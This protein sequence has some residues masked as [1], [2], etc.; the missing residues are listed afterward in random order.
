MS[1]AF[2]ALAGV[3]LGA[4]LGWGL[5]LGTEVWRE[6]LQNTKR[7]RHF[8]LEILDL[9][10]QVRISEDKFNAGSVAASDAIVNKLPTIDSFKEISL[11]LSDE[12]VIFA[13]QAVLYWNMI[14]RTE[15]TKIP[16][17]TALEGLA[18]MI[19]YWRPLRRVFWQ[20]IHW[21]EAGKCR[22]CIEA[23]L[24]EN[25]SVIEMRNGKK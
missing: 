19:S 21:K 11:F 4:V 5:F 3:T 2:F 1:E 24:N 17:L 16:E 23:L 7:L 18:E 15:P 22:A 9:I 6:R 13:G 25:P 14:R 8:E 12:E 10:T 20:V